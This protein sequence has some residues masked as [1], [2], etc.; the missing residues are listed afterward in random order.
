MCTTSSSDRATT[1]STCL[2][3]MCGLGEGE[4]RTFLFPWSVRR[5]VVDAAR[6]GEPYDVV[7]VHEPHGAPVAALRTDNAEQRSWP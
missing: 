7:N 1:C 2:P 4:G 6:R 5:A 3:T